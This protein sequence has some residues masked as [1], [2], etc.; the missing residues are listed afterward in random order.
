MATITS[1]QVNRGD[2]ARAGIP[3][4]IGVKGVAA[5]PATGDGS[6]AG[7]ILQMVTVPKGAT[8]LDMALSAEDLDTNATPTITLS[9]GDGDD[10]DRFIV[11]S[12]VAQ[13]G[14]I[15]RL[16]VGVAAADIDGAHGFKYTAQDTIDVKIVAA[17]ATKAA[18]NI[19]LTVW[20]TLDEQ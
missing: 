13:A 11:A 1:T 14:G 4:V 7:D 10:D 12:T 19:T 8:I 16:G 15:V 3:G 18:G 2:Q 9:V 20:Y 6:A 17:A 5:H